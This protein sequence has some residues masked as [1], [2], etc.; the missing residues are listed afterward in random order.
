MMKKWLAVA[1][2]AGLSQAA[3]AA[4]DIRFITEA[5]YPPFEYMDEQN[6]FQGFDI[7]VARAICAVIEANCSFH[8]HA[9]DSLI[10]ALKFNKGDAAI[11]A[12]D[13]TPE[14]QENVDFSDIYYENAA[15]FVAK[16]GVFA[17]AQ[18]LAGKSVAVQNGT[19]HQKYIQDQWSDKKVTAVPYASYQ[20]AFLDLKTGRV[21]AVFADTAVAKE[22]LDQQDA[23]SY[24]YVGEA[25]TDAAYFGTGFGIAV[26]KGNAELLAELNRGLKEIRANGTYQ[27]IYDKFFGD[28]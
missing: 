28:K 25:V 8:N 9:F 10:P 3:W 7:E 21:D 18:A 12:M 26:K 23:G 6:E 5:T 4:Q 15:V 19:S 16:S 14:R 11:A 13:V 20:N 24:Q 27:Q 1:M 2:A 17:D 22:W